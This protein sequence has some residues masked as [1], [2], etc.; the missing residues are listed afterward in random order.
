MTAEKEHHRQVERIRDNPRLIGL[1]DIVLS[2][3]ECSL[4]HPG[5]Q[6]LFVKPDHHMISLRDG[7]AFVEYK[8]TDR[9]VTHAMKQLLKAYVFAQEVWGVQPALYFAWGHPGKNR[10]VRV[11]TWEY[12]KIYAKAMTSFYARY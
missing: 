9:N 2:A 4:W 12:A 10:C 6:Q 7:H 11:H 5:S 3:G 1:D 8:L